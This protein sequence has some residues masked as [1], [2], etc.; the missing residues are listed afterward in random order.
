MPTSNNCQLNLDVQGMTCASCVARVERALNK[1]DGVQGASVN[2]ATEKATVTYLPDSVSP[3]ELSAAV[4]QAGYEVRAETPDQNRAESLDKARA[5]ELRQLKTSLT[6]AAI[7]TVPL[8][9]LVMVP[10]LVP[11]LGAQLNRFVPAQTVFYGS[12]VLATIVQFGPGRRFYR[13]GWP[14]LRRGSPDMNTLVLLGTSAAY[15]Y[16]VVATFLPGLLPAGTVHVYFEASA[17]I[18]TLILLGKYLE[19][20]AKGRTGEAIKKLVNLQPKTA[21]VERGGGVARA[22]PCRR[23]TGR[24]RIGAPR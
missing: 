22:A 10:M 16:S 15:G 2:L 20:R 17:T 9:L 13:S 12:F 3:A 19:A 11:G 14:A 7:F 4:R 24:H 1:V 8:I 6:I 5:D 18:I 23:R 21:R